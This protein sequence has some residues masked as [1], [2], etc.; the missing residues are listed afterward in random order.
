LKNNFFKILKHHYIACISITLLLNFIL[1][2]YALNSRLKNINEM[3]S[4][5]EIVDYAMSYISNEDGLNNKKLLDCS[6]F[7]RSVYAHFNIN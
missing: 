7:I 3:P 5:Q 2:A 6:G 1:N 4:G